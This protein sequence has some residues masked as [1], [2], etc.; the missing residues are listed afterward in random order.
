MNQEVG[1]HLLDGC[2]QALQTLWLCRQ[3]R[4]DDAGLMKMAMFFSSI[5]FLDNTVQ[6]VYSIT[7]YIYIHIYYI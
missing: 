6:A 2:R 1:L 3:R 4:T 7:I 5:A